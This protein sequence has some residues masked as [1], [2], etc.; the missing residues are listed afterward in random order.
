MEG[1]DGGDRGPATLAGEGVGKD[2][3]DGNALA[4]TT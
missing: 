1:T 4:I 3:V 2:N